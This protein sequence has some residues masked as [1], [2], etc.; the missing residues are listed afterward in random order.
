MSERVDKWSISC[1][2]IIKMGH[3]FK[4]LGNTLDSSLKLDKEGTSSH[5]SKE[6]NSIL[7]SGDSSFMFSIKVGPGF[8]FHISLSLSSFNSSV[9]T[10]KFSKSL[11]ELFFG[12][13]KKVFGV[14]NSFV[15]C[16]GGSSMHIHVIFI[17][18]NKSIAC[19]SGLSMI[20]ITNSLSVV[21]FLK[22]TINH[23]G[24]IGEISL[25]GHVE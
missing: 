8:V 10:G 2:L 23:V 9:N 18:R 13:S 22:K 1:E 16:C 19:S 20:G 12:I 5:G 17:F 11:F 25:S 3:V 24:D 4:S 6:I 15:T 7:T 21:A 14:G